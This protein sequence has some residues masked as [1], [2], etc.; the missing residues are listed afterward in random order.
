MSIKNKKGLIQWALFNAYG[1][2]S[3]PLLGITIHDKWLNSQSKPEA[4]DLT[5][6]NL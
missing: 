6:R 1:F 5:T 4:L 3:S 2:N